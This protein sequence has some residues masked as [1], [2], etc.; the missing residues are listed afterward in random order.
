MRFCVLLLLTTAVL[1][2]H[3]SSQAFALPEDPKPALTVPVQA[4]LN[5]LGEGQPGAT[6]EQDAGAVADGSKQ[7]KDSS[8]GGGKIRVR[9]GS[10]SFGTGYAHYSGPAYYPY[11]WY[12]HDWAYSSYFWDPYWDAYPH[13]YGSAYFTYTPSRGEVRLK[14]EPNTA[15]VY[16]DG[17]YAGTADRLKS[18]WLEPGAYDLSLSTKDGQAFHQRIY[19]LSGKSLKIN[20]KLVSGN[21]EEKR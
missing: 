19:V 1:G 21:V 8:E 2:Y 17:A 9:L 15:E 13:F 3:A 14:A 11:G 10:I 12:P 6:T 5:D 7:E 20:A 16:L 18:M 4:S